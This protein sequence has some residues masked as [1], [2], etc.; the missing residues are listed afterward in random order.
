MWNH[1]PEVQG[2]HG[3]YD[4][5]AEFSCMKI[6]RQHRSNHTS[7]VSV[8]DENCFTGKEVCASSP[9]STTVLTFLVDLL[10]QMLQQSQLT[11]WP[12]GTNT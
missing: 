6:K 11:N 10:P 1:I 2:N 8:W 5:V 7:M 4:L 3:N 9:F 12:G